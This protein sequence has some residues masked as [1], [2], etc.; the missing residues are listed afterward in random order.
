MVSAPWWQIVTK[1]HHCS[2][3]SWDLPCLRL[4]A[5]LRLQTEVWLWSVTSHIISV[6]TA[7]MRVDPSRLCRCCQ[8]A[9]QYDRIKKFATDETPYGLN[10]NGQKQVTTSKNKIGYICWTCNT[11]ERKGFSICSVI[12]QWYSDFCEQWSAFKTCSRRRTAESMAGW[13]KSRC[14]W[15]SKTWLSPREHTQF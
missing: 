6:H 13:L 15:V 10:I 12:F 14:T 11:P 1:H 5:C 4:Q 9:L 8:I 3:R 7:R 2:N